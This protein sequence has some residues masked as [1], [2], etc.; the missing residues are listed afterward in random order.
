[1]TPTDVINLGLDMAGKDSI[2]NI[3]DTDTTANRARRSYHPLRD[4]VLRDHFWNFAITRKVL[5]QNAV[6]PVSGFVYGY[7]READDLRVLGINEDPTLAWQV[8]GRDI[9]TDET[10]VTAKCIYRI[11]NPDLWDPLFLSM[12]ST[13]LASRYALIFSHDAKF[14]MALL[15]QYLLLKNDAQAVDGQEGSILTYSS[16]ALTTDVRND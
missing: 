1:M 7:K 4:A 9:V 16:T 3:D 12:F 11:T 6:A 2:T 15:E 13:L 5:E 14:S 8:E 10:A